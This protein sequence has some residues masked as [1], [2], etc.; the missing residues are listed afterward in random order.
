MAYRLLDH[1]GDFALEITAADRPGVYPEACRA[2]LDLVTDAPGTVREEQ[3]RDL[4]VE[5]LDP[6]D[7]LVAL[8]NE[9]IFLFEVEGLLVARLE[10]RSLDDAHLE[11]TAHGERFD[12]DRHPI[13]RPVKAA[14]HH[15][16]LLEEDAEGGRAFVVM[17]L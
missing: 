6:A 5:G 14:T 13:A 16:V 15:R 1:T 12:P 3:A 7:L 8:L 9:L 10:L 2:F 17:D 4:E 11:A